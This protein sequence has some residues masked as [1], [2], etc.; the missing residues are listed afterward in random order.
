MANYIILSEQVLK[1]KFV[2]NMSEGEFFRFCQDNR[3]LKFEREANG[4]I[5]FMSPTTFLT[6]SR[7]NEIL[8]QIQKWNK[9]KKLGC[10]VDSDTGFT[11]PNGAVR[12]PDAAWVSNQRLK[13][14]PKE[15]LDKFPKLVPDFIVELKSKHDNLSDLKKKMKEWM[16]NGC[17]LGWLI[18]TD[19][20]VVYIYEGVEERVHQG[21]NK[22]LSGEPVL[23]GF[24]MK[25]SSLK[26]IL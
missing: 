3:D 14:I 22:S 19:K 18:D 16:G 10:T 26:N 1:G 20:E 11:L 21:F 25:L 9:A 8:F 13:K 6:G 17:R 12:N 24:K 2:E 15:E 5:I 23:A 4:Q 7:N